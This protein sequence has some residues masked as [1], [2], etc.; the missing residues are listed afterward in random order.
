MCGGISISRD[1]KIRIYRNKTGNLGR[2]ERRG[3]MID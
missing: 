2:E 1:A 3:I